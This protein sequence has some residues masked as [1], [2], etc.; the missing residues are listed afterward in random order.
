[1]EA[2]NF[3]NLAR[4]NTV[5]TQPSLMQ[6]NQNKVKVRL[7]TLCTDWRYCDQE[8]AIMEHCFAN[9][10]DSTEA[11]IDPSTFAEKQ[12]NLLEDMFKNS[13]LRA[14]CFD[15]ALVSRSTSYENMFTL[16]L[17]FQQKVHEVSAF[18]NS[19]ISDNMMYAEYG[20]QQCRNRCKLGATNRKEVMDY[21][22]LKCTNLTHKNY[23]M[24]QSSIIDKYD[25]ILEKLIDNYGVLTESEIEEKKELENR[26]EGGGCHV[27]AFLTRSF[28]QSKYDVSVEV[29]VLDHH[30]FLVIGRAPDSDSND[31]TTWGVEA[32]ICDP[33]ADKAYPAYHF[34]EMQE[35][36]NIAFYDVPEGGGA[37]TTL[38]TEHYLTGFPQIYFPK[39]NVKSTSTE[40]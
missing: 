23:Y 22:V 35:T 36:A 34:K 12:L 24:A 39:Y 1:M 2:V 9:I 29:A 11:K 17:E 33:W 10:W 27:L 32:V 5:I 25:S 18:G 13:D 8:R 28:I 15:M 14:A 26:L 20:L 31:I 3:S 6:I 21:Y 4:T 19:K 40:V 16:F 30:Q 38:S 37:N 7:D